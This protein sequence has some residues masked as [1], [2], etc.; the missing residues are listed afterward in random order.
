MTLLGTRSRE[1]ERLDTD[2]PS[3]EELARSLSFV[4]EVNRA[5]G[6][7]RWLRRR[8]GHL[9]G[10]RGVRL[11]DVGAGNGRVLQDLLEWGHASGGVRWTGVGLDLRAAMLRVAA[12]PTARTGGG[13]RLVRG[14]GRLLPFGAGAFDA[15]FSTL[16]LHHLSTDGAVEVVSEMARVSS[17]SV[18]V[19]DLE[20]SLP[21]YLGARFLAETRWR[22]DSITRNDGPLS[23]RRAFSAEELR[24]LAR[25]ARLQGARVVHRFPFLVLSGGP[26]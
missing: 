2:C 26:A 10:R 22:G 17:G 18:V 23:V 8:L 15:A 6:A 1:Q 5:L 7:V 20:R 13:L 12:Q 9:A 14:D 25:R 16:T 11:L 24:V 4:T 19:I 21:A 3:T